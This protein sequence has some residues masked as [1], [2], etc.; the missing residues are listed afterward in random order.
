MPAIDTTCII[1]PAVEIQVKVLLRTYRRIRR[2]KH[3]SLIH[4]HLRSSIAR[5]LQIQKPIHIRSDRD[6]E[7]AL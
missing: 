4:Q 3:K 5:H 7:T 1:P 6:W 2:I